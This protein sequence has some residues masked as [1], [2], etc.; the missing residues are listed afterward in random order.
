MSKIRK[1]A[2]PTVELRPSRIRRDPVPVAEAAG[3]KKLRWESDER[4]IWIALIGI[5]AFALAIDIIIVAISTY[6][7]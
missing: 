4:D 1:A 3:E 2:K 6:W 5:V 7:N